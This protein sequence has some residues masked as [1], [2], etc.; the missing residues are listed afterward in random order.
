LLDY[1]GGFFAAGTEDVEIRQAIGEWNRL[2]IFKTNVRVKRRP[3]GSSDHADKLTI[4]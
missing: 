2:H 3:D 1:S 4:G